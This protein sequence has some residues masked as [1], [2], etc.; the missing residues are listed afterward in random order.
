[1]CSGDELPQKSSSQNNNP[2]GFWKTVNDL[3]EKDK[4]IETGVTPKEL[5][6]KSEHEK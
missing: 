1:M 2:I 5:I 3:R 4:H 6:A